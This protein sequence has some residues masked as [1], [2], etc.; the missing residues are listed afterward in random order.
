MSK[1]DV[2]LCPRTSDEPARAGGHQHGAVTSSPLPAPSRTRSCPAPTLPEAPWLS[3]RRSP[4]AE[5]ILKHF[6]FI[7]LATEMICLL[8]I[9]FSQ[10]VQH[11][12]PAASA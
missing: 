8:N 9:S 12:C 6:Q 2:A 5:S 4:F 1:Q 11:S 10:L 3:V 7:D